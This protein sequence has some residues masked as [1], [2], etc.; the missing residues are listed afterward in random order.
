MDFISHGLWG[1]IAFGRRNRSSFWLAFAIGMAPDLFS[2][3]AL[4]VAATF[5]LS[6]KPDFSHG[7]PP[8]S[9]IPPYVHHLYDYTH[10]FVI[11]LLVFFLIWLVLKR[12]VWE[13]GAWGLH[14]LADMPLH[15]YAFFPTPVLWPFSDWKFDGWQW[16]TPGILI[17]NFALLS[18]LYTWY[19]RQL[20]LAKKRAKT[21]ITSPRETLG[22]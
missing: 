8:E 15:S 20:F 17:T 9:T 4:Y 10:S 1:S 7:T 21:Q 5:G 11:F 13:L 2:F 19:I 12:P 6:P 14:I 18:L 3:G 22:R 16:T